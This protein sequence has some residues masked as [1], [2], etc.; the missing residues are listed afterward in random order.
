[1]K[2]EQ[3]IGARRQQQN[4]QI[5]SVKYEEGGKE[6]SMK[7]VY[8]IFPNYD[9]IL[10]QVNNHGRGGDGDILKA[11]LFGFGIR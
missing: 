11:K 7:V 3:E 5:L 10:S 8:R 1:M 2:Q 4:E 9:K 6:T